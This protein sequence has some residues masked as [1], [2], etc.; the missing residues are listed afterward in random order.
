[1]N[2]I[3]KDFHHHLKNLHVLYVEDSATMRHATEK[4][5][6]PYFN[7]ID[8]AEDGIL[9][10][11]LYRNFHKQHEK[12]YDIVITDLEMPNMDGKE[13][14]RAILSIDPSQEI[15]IISSSNDL[16]ILIDLINIG[17]RKFLAKPIQTQQLHNTISEVAA[18]LRLK[19]LKEDELSDIS[20]HN[21]LLRKREEIYLSK[22]E[23]SFQELSEFND[24]L[25]ASGIVSK[26]NPLGIITYVNAKFCELSGYSEEKLVGNKH[27]LV[28]C[29]EM[30]SSFFEKLWHT[31]TAKKIYKGIFKNRTK[32]GTIYYVEQLIKP[33][34]NIEGEIIEYIAIGH[35]IT[36]MMESI[37]IAKR[38]EEGKDDFFR[39]ISHEMRTPLNSILGL[40]SLLK[41]R[42]KDD[43]KLLDMLSVIESNSQNLSSLI[44]SI[45]D[46]QRLH[47]NELIFQ[48]YE[49][50]TSALYTSIIKQ[51]ESKSI[52]KN[53]H[54]EYAMDSDVPSTLIGDKSR[55]AQIIMA[56]MDNAIKFSLKD[57]KVTLHFSYSHDDS[58][59]IVQVSD[60]GIGIS[61]AD[62]E[63]IFNLTQADG[64]LS[65]K[66]EGSGLGLTISNSLIK[67]MGGSF[68]MHSI[69]GE[70]STFLMEI[71]LRAPGS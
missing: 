29:G 48:I 34:L 43:T 8:S 68:T 67:K 37:E 9:G 44:E 21:I 10:L 23:K 57:G 55:I 52:E 65:R 17:V 11:E 7:H 59:F 15:I 42:A 3:S 51:N 6:T 62:K 32:V 2:E 28:N 20:K 70:G 12:N 40:T 66:H 16:T 54:L 33:I 14:A 41:R 60:S 35:D 27:T 58:M 50:D 30:S 19:K 71:P 47:H 5:L 25:N 31:I 38:A 69:L 56:V 61:V 53:L 49:F 45:L 36:Q 24:A 39:N 26:T 46:L 1:V 4:L 22:L 18:N 13:L 63:K 64:S